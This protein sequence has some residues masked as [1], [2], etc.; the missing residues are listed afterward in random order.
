MPVSAYVKLTGDENLANLGPVRCN[1]VTYTKTAIKNLGSATVFVKYPGQPVTKLVFNVTDQEG[2]TLICCE[3]LLA[4]GLVIPKSGLEEIP[5]DAHLVSSSS[6]DNQDVNNMTATPP[7]I[8]CKEDIKKHYSDCL[9]GL[10][11]FPGAPYHINVDPNVPPVQVPCRKVDVHFEAAF[12]QQLNDMLQAGVIVPQEEPTP[13]IN[14]FVI[15][16]S[17]NKIRVC[18]DP[19]NL[20][21]AVIREPYH[22]R[23]PEDI[24][25]KLSKAKFFTVVDLKKGY[26]QIPLDEQSSTLPPS[27]HL[28]VDT[29]LPEFLLESL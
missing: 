17:K 1:M 25:H 14:S 24:Y 19:T 23:T 16:H 27:T 5:S 8:T 18:L 9:E 10:G 3:D 11:K 12:K 29:D 22:Y 4:L 2:S 28:L 26:W 20:N 7:L 15:V 21:K 6:D 13:W